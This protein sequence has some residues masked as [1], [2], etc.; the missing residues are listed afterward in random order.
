MSDWKKE[1]EDTYPSLF[2]KLH[3]GISIGDGWKDIMKTLCVMMTEN[4]H[5]VEDNDGVE[6]EPSFTQIKEKFG[7]LRIYAMNVSV[8]QDAYISFAEEHSRH[9]CEECGCPGTIRPGGW[10]RTLC[11]EHAGIK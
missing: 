5:V 8:E 4:R 7:M 11:D 10:I 3:F 9:V 1:L 2:A 6:L